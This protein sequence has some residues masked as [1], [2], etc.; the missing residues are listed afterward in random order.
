MYQ[1]NCPKCNGRLML[2]SFEACCQAL[3]TEDGFSLFDSPFVD[4]TEEVVQCLD[5][6]ALMPLNPNAEDGLVS[7]LPKRSLQIT[8]TDRDGAE[9]KLFLHECECGRLVECSLAGEKHYI[10]CRCGRTTKFG[11]G[12]LTPRCLP[13]G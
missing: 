6:K 9:R 4:T 1:T 2:I 12:P 7:E 13:E 10:H 8:F 5:C 3:I 11:T